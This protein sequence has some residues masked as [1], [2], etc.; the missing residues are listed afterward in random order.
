M[1]VTNICNTGIAFISKGIK[2]EAKNRSLKKH[3]LKKFKNISH[4]LKVAQKIYF[5]N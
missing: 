4:M 3:V 5:Y 1:L 2:V